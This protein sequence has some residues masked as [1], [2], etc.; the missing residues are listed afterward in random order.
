MSENHHRVKFQLNR[1]IFDERQLGFGH[2]EETNRAYFGFG[3]IS[4]KD[5]N[6]FI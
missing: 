4:R 2:Q 6:S 1:R 3:S 5:I